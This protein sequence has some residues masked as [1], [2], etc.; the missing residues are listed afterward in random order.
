MSS[1]GCAAHPVDGFLA[2]FFKFELE[3]GRVCEPGELYGALQI[4]KELH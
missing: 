3:L 1:E 2:H 4:K